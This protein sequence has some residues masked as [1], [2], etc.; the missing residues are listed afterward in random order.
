MLQAF[1]GS[2]FFPGYFYGFWV[3]IFECIG[4]SKR[5]LVD[6]ICSRRAWGGGSGGVM[7]RSERSVMNNNLYGLLENA[8][9]TGRD[10][11]TKELL[12]VGA[13]GGTAGTKT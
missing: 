7:D 4:F 3:D 12:Q 11:T 9:A 1:D 2:F 13:C 5:G 10:V 6:E 8:L